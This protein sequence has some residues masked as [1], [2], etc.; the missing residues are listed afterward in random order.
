[1]QFTVKN[2]LITTLQRNGTEN[3]NKETAL[4]GKMYQHTF[5]L[6]ASKLRAREKN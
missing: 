1:M 5:N 3:E 6:M 4:A 2:E